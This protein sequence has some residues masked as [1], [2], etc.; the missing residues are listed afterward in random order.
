MT[1]DDI[2]QR[3]EEIRKLAGDGDHDAAHSFEDRL[4]QDVLKAI[5]SGLLADWQK[6]AEIALSTKQIE[7]HRWVQ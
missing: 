6:G 4:H 1:L 3:V 7:F 5:S 2:K